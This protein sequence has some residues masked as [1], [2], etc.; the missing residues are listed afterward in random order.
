MRAFPL[1]LI[2]LLLPGVSADASEEERPP[3]IVLIMADDLGYETLGCNGGT[4]Y[5]TPH[6]DALAD[7]GARFTRAY[8]TP[9]CTPSRVQLLTGKYSFRNYTA[10]GFLD[11]GET[12]IAD[13][14]KA[15]GYATCVV[16]KW[17]LCGNTRRRE[18]S[19]RTGTRPE[20]AG[21]DEYCLWQIRENTGSRY[22]HPWLAVNA[23]EAREY[24]GDYGPDR[25]CAMAEDFMER[26]R[27]RPFFLYY[28]MALVHA[29]FQPTP[30]D[31]GYEGFDPR[32]G[33]SDPALFAANIAAMDAIVGRIVRKLGDLG[34]RD[35]T[36][37]LFVG[38][39]GTDRAIESAMGARSIRGRKGYTTAAGTHVPLIASW[40]GTVPAGV[41]R[42][43]LVDFT[44]F[45]P[46]LLAVAGAA[47]PA[48]EPVDGVSLLPAM[49]GEP[50]PRRDWVFCHY[51]PRWGNFA[52]AR[53]VH[54]DT[55]KLYGNGALYHLAEDPE[56][57]TPVARASLAE[58][59]AAAVER[60][61]RVL[62]RLR[63]EPRERPNVIVILTDDQGSVDMGAYGA[64]DLVTP[65][66]DRL[67]AGGIRFTHF[68]AGGPV[69][70]PSRAS[71][72]TGKTPQA[73][74]VPGNVGATAGQTSGLPP[75]EI[76]LAEMFRSA[77]YRTAHIGK[78][79]LGYTPERSPNAQGFDY[80]FGHM[81]GCI[82]NWSHFFYWNGPNRHDLYKN[83]EEVFRPGQYFPD[84]MLR[85]AIQF[86]KA[87]RE[88][89]FF[90]YFA[91]N[92]PHYPYQGEEKWL[93][94]Y[95]ARG[96]P[97]PRNL[98][99]AFLTSADARI[100]AL[101]DQVDELGLAEDTI[102]VFQ[103]DHGHSTE[104][105]AHYG[106]GSA[107]SLRGAKSSLFEGGIRVPAIVSWPGHLQPGVRDAVA[108]S[109]DWLP[110]LAEL[111]DLPAPEHAIDGE[112]LVPLL[113]DAGAGS[114]HDVLHW[115]LGKRWAVRRGDW[116][117]LFRPLDN[118]DPRNATPLPEADEWFLANVALEEDERTNR[119]AEHPELVAE[120][121][122][123][124]EAW[125]ETH[126]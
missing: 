75:E 124:H 1:G 115:Q 70:S 41:V 6:L 2:A 16:G 10:F 113:R 17:Q 82:D 32:R 84:L 88:R 24:R 3:N 31:P 119:A 21:F 73:A 64:R 65:H 68:Y 102:V 15:V 125:V 40:P 50:G 72:L 94:D 79:H 74:G 14:L 7:A 26:N 22:K 98:Y 53:Y 35:D 116:K 83:G 92:A 105:R 63:P 52:N 23:Q 43:E 8:S 46:T 67:A 100:G 76:T 51:E 33:G 118:G 85:E 111:C 59:D 5:S 38:D 89:P 103:S 117:L 19:G 58:A 80:S 34:L 109:A 108:V 18:L 114:P 99:G 49:L 81:V 28:P 29:P 4:S 123:L 54:D 62:D 12:T 97:Y 110:T 77:G 42:D 9:L 101:L 30:R 69:C 39:N 122:A 112:S 55:W 20:E 95:D 11:P 61:E 13:H 86:M 25:F 120:L 126:R 93:A 27:E 66:M 37:L 48:G 36:L 90:I 71:L 56:E 121:R 57:L 104:Q 91:M 87:N 44:D 45:L 60:F 96:V 106:G 47:L 107:G 78:W